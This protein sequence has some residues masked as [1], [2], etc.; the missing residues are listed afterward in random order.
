MS[1]IST[2]V[3]MYEHTVSN[4][5]IGTVLDY[6]IVIFAFLS[7]NPFFGAVRNLVLIYFLGFLLFI[8]YQK[9]INLYNQ[10][11]VLILFSLYVLIII[12]TIIYGGFSRAGIIKPFTFFFIPYLIYRIVGINFLKY[13]SNAI[14]W[15][16]LITLP[17]WFLQSFFDPFDNFI[18]T[19]IKSLYPLSWSTTPRSMLIYT[20]IITSAAN[21][22]HEIFG[23]YRN[24]G[25]FHEPGAYGVFLVFG[26]IINH[27]YGKRL[28]TNKNILMMFAILTTMSTAAYIAIF[29]YINSVLL[30][31]KSN[32]IIKISAFGLFALISLYAYQ[33]Q[34]FLQSKVTSQYERQS[35]AANERVGEAIGQSGRFFALFTSLR[36]VTEHPIFGRGIIDATNEI[37]AGIMHEKAAYKYGIT[38]FLSTYGIIFGLF[39]ILNLYRGYKTLISLKGWSI[40]IVIGAFLTINMELQTQTFFEESFFVFFFVLGVFYRESTTRK[41]GLF[42]IFGSQEK[43]FSQMIEYKQG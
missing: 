21:V 32:I 12:Q 15:F 20:S 27:I 14:F 22:K 19:T 2:K 8:A 31:S 9:R 25:L 40:I 10:K 33:S 37:N 41:I 11:V 35:F 30:S 28:F 13:T 18:Y 4:Y 16:T 1:I 39:F 3:R 17:I 43:K 26:I 24:A 29:L 42:D 23:V 36:L 38:G 5:R 34:D 6:V 7:V